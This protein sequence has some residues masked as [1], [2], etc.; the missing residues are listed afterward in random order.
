MRADRQATLV[1]L[2]VL[3]FC[4]TGALAV[5][6]AEK[7][8]VTL[9][10][11]SQVSSDQ[12]FF[13]EIAHITG[14]QAM[15][16]RIGQVVVAPAAREGRSQRVTIG[17]IEVRLRQA[18]IEPRH[19]LWQGATEIDV[20]TKASGA[21]V[22][23][24]VPLSSSSS[25]GMDRQQ[26]PSP[27]DRLENYHVVVARATLAR[28]QVLTRDQISLE[29]REGIVPTHG[30]QRLED[31]IGKRVTR[32]VPAGSQLSLAIVEAPP[33]V[34]MGDRI[35]ILAEVR[36][37]HVSVPGRALATGAIG[38]M[39]RVEN[40]NTRQTMS[41]KIVSADTVQIEIGGNSF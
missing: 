30:S 26:I 15:V 13:R 22:V 25:E 16:E 24:A 35:T 4:S 17:H 14:E 36:G 21:P 6:S 10:G 2:L 7:L 39:I 27:P 23:T 1:L 20:Y 19:L 31:F 40:T 8:T 29:E 32:V 34:G 11:E 5:D 41:A 12:I 33:V 9:Y 28:H 37:I 38:D 3:V 18:G